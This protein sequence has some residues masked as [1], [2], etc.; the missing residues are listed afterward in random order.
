MTYLASALLPMR[1]RQDSSSRPETYE[2]HLVQNKDCM[3]DGVRTPKQEMQYGSALSSPSVVS[4]GHPTT[5]HPI[6]KTRAAFFESP[7]SISIGFYNTT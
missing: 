2:S 7:L 5:E 4:H 1:F 6:R 3:A